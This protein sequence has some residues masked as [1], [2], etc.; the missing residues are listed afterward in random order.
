MTFYFFLN[1]NVFECEFT[2][3]YNDIISINVE[4][5]NMECEK[6]N[7]LIFFCENPRSNIE[8]LISNVDFYFNHDDDNTLGQITSH[9]LINYCI[10]RHH[11][12][13]Q[14]EICVIFTRGYKIIE[15]LI[16]MPTYDKSF[17]RELQYHFYSKKEEF[18]DICYEIKPNIINVHENCE[19]PKHSFCIDCILKTEQ[20]CPL[21]RQK[22]C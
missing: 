12:Y 13:H 10:N 16:Y 8:L 3:F 22:I 19:I 9:I 1:H 2:K 17:L 21:C 14:Y 18:C 20:K 4:H 15:F 7:K 11:S 6:H 5:L